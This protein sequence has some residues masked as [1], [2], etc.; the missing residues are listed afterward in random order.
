MPSR[1]SLL[2][3]LTLATVSAAAHA[4]APAAKQPQPL[5]V[6]PAPSDWQITASLPLWISGVDGTVGVRG[7][8]A[9]TSANFLD[10]V[11]NLDMI[12]AGTVEIRKGRW[13]GWIDGAY[14]QASV[15][16]ATPGPLLDSLNVG[17][18]QVTLEAAAFYRAWQS[19]RG[20]LDLYAGAR[21]WSVRS[22]LEFDID[23]RGLRQ[24][25][26][27]LSERA[28]AQVIA[29]VQRRV[30]GGAVTASTRA[31]SRIANDIAP[32]VRSRVADVVA[33]KQEEVRTVLGNLQQ[34][35]AAHP[36]LAELLRRSDRVKEA[37]EAAAE[38]RLAEQTALVQ[39]QADQ[40]RATGAAA[41]RKVAAAAASASAR[42]R[43][44]VAKA[45]QKLARE[46]E[47][48]LREA[49]PATVA[50]SADWVD[51]FVGLRGLYRFNDRFYAIAKADIGGFSVGSDLT[52]S[53]YAA[54]GMQVTASGNTTL[55]LGY[56]HLALDYVNGGFIYDMATSGPMLNLSIRF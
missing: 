44:K 36:R 40:L 38:A 29:E 31:A 55:E 24:V 6:L 13:G 54:L 8:T 48:A 39:A 20:F 32:A 7:F 28:M 3:L 27:E 45:E 26:E 30:R 37:I 49:L 47:S 23:D 16:A 17:I 15:G 43:R 34:I 14:L 5:E 33:T 35:A 21:Y 52:W 22:S 41:R 56:K 11:R 50:Q 25:S 51:P 53:A 12:A 19:E 9:D 2:S 42:A 10:I 4:G 46:L 1:L 18:E